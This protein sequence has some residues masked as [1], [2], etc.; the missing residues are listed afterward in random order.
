MSDFIIRNKPIWSELEQ[1]VAR[2]R[3]RIGGMTPE[4]LARLDALYRRT[5]IH[6]AQ[7]VTRTQDAR[8]AK[9]LNDL[10]AAAHSIIYLPPRKS[11]FA[12]TLKFILEGFGRAVARTWRYHLAA[13][14]LVLG[15]A[16][17]AY[18][19]A[20]NDT[21]A[22][23][24]LSMSPQAGDIRT[25]GSTPEQLRNV[26]K[27]GREQE[28]STKFAF[29]SFLFSHNLQVGIMSLCLG[30]L[31]GIPTIFLLL[32]NGMILG[33]FTAMHHQAGIYADY[34]AWILPHA[35]SE[36]S[37]II[38][39]GGVGLMLGMAV[40]SPGELTRAE[41][42]RRVGREAAAVCL[43]VAGMLV[44]AAAVES[45]LRQSNLSNAARFAFAAASA[46]FWAIYFSY[47]ALRE[48]AA[49]REDL[50]TESA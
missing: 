9:Y 36:L 47:G 35:V 20:G 46:V 30:I 18:F 31:A 13:A 4:E 39:C 2:A 23:Y 42:L 17:F 48:H 11:A 41:S 29:A 32:Y 27:H 10:T 15:G 28:A 12:G 33:S 14:V 38:L 16:L 22:A 5:T 24:A 21:L 45:F 43:G 50:M 6:L 26:L 7:V 37:A 8:L 1:L 25:P 49:R 34:W 40:L 44:I 3:K 19:A